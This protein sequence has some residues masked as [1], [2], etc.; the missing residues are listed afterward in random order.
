[1]KHCKE[2]RRLTGKLL[3]F[4]VADLCNGLPIK[5][6]ERI[7]ARNHH[8]QKK[9]T[10]HVVQ[11]VNRITCQL[12]ADP[13]VQG[14]NTKHFEAQTVGDW[15]LYRGENLSAHYR[16]K[17]MGAWVGPIKFGVKL[18]HHRI[19]SLGFSQSTLLID[20]KQ[21]TI[22]EGKTEIG[23]R[24]FV[25][26]NGSKFTFSTGDGE[27]VDFVSYGYFF[28][29]FVRSSAKR[30]TGLC[31][32]EFIHSHFFKHEEK[33]EIVK[34]MKKHCPRRKEFEE[35]CQRSGLLRTPLANC[36]FD[37]CSGLP[38]RVEK[39]MLKTIK[40]E[41]KKEIPIKRVTRPQCHLIADPHAYGFNGKN[42]E[43]Q[44]EGDWVLYKG[45]NLEVYYRG[46]RFA[47]Q[48]WVANQKFGIMLYG[49]KIESINLGDCSSLIIDGEHHSVNGRFDLKRGGFITGNKQK[50]VISTGDGEDVTFQV[51]YMNNFDAYVNSNVP[52]VSGLCSQEFTKAN[53]FSH[54]Q[55]G[56][57]DNNFHIECHGLRTKYD[58][59]CQKLG[60]VNQALKNCVMDRCQGLGKKDEK[61]LFRH[62]RH[63]KE[64]KIII[65]K[66]HNVDKLAQ[67]KSARLK[68][69][70]KDHLKKLIKEEHHEEHR[71]EEEHLRHEEHKH[72]EEHLRHE[73]I[74][75]AEIRH[76]EQRH[77][78]VRHEEQRHQ[79]IRHEEHHDLPPPHHDAPQHGITHEISHFVGKRK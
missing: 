35:R 38:K 48:G 1:M 69:E 75:H 59:F 50:I 17:S 42:F 64:K 78:E 16:G 24:G 32:Q 29:G 55:E 37:L 52:T 41:V 68:H 10:I 34:P 22:S 13:H 73:E 57:I 66:Q 15:V 54:P 61:G 44:V 71:H 5:F 65:E 23:H 28:N 18:F 76:E 53:F 31:S 46:K 6:E 27:E 36:I 25:F 12:Y 9:K 4:C 21:V 63:E 14:F 26:K 70:I 30:V 58:E 45:L 40:H 49:Q 67:I 39:K 3:K 77:Q 72:E 19:Y 43:A 51:G 74:R 47:G 79:E 20:G 2:H 8:E 11:K 62:I 33:G 56:H 7:I 60:L